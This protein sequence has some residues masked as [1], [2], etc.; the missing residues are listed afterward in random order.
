MREARNLVHS[1]V[2]CPSREGFVTL[3]RDS[4][5]RAFSLFEKVV[6]YE[7]LIP[8]QASSVVRL[9]TPNE[10]LA[11]QKDHLCVDRE[12]TRICGL[13]RRNLGRAMYD[14]M[15]TWSLLSYS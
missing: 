12:C 10:T 7:V 3:C 14:V 11:N 13:S 1:L 9:F 8:E 4:L 15:L 6:E 2:H 5:L